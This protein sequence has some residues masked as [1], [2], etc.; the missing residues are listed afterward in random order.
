MPTE[1]RG[2]PYVP[3]LRQFANQR[4]RLDPQ[5]INQMMTELGKMISGIPPDKAMKIIRQAY[6]QAR[7]WWDGNCLLNNN[8]SFY[9]P[10]TGTCF[11]SRSTLAIQ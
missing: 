5:S 11:D 9:D 8:W 2:R 3:D 1:P 10:H 4:S 6:R 7:N